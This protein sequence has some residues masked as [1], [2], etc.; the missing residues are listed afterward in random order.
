[1]VLN[2]QKWFMEQQKKLASS[3]KP[4]P[5]PPRLP[6]GPLQL[7]CLLQVLQRPHPTLGPHQGKSIIKVQWVLSSKYNGYCVIDHITVSKIKGTANFLS[8]I[9]IT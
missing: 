8:K 7:L 5:G 6:R 3:P 2:H 9:R 4:E 1:M